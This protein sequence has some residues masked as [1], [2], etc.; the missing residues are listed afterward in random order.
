M[1]GLSEAPAREGGSRRKIMTPSRRLPI[2][3]DPTSDGREK[4]P[5]LRWLL[6]KGVGKDIM[7]GRACPDSASPK[8]AVPMDVDEATPIKRKRRVKGI[9]VQQKKITDVWK[10]EDK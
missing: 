5:T 7:D 4:A 1:E 10:R 2:P 8:R 6:G 9:D 3:S